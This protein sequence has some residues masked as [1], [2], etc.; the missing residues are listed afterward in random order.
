MAEKWLDIAHFC[1]RCELQLN[2]F[3]CS[4]RQFIEKQY[5]FF[6]SYHLYNLR[7]FSLWQRR[8]KICFF[9]IWVC[10][11]MGIMRF[12]ILMNSNSILLFSICVGLC[13]SFPFIIIAALT[14]FPNQHNLNESLSLTAVQASWLGNRTIFNDIWATIIIYNERIERHFLFQWHFM[15]AWFYF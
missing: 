8:L 1:R 5:I 9:S 10:V 7:Q 13:N 11:L 15:F 12:C 6:P 2:G 4:S 3:F 14:G